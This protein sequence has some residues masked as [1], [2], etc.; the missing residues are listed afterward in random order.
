MD[1]RVMQFRVGVMVLR[2]AAH[3]RHP[4]GDVRQAAELVPR[5]VHGAR[6]LRRRP[7]RDQR[8]A[9]AQERHPHRPG[10]RRRVLEA[11]RRP[12]DQPPACLSSRPTNASFATTK[13]RV[14]TSSLLGDSSIQFVVDPAKISPLRCSWMAIERRRRLRRSDP[15]GRQ[16]AGPPLRWPSTP[17]PT[18]ATNSAWSSTQVG[19][20]L[21]TNKEPHQQ[22]PGKGR[23]HRR[24]GRNRHRS[25]TSTT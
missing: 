19:E 24:H 14:I 20:L 18:P 6:R 8:H 21:T 3:H 17:W 7:G 25:R 23:H 15:G 9:G 4:A 5:Q 16:T 22:H 12:G 1:E 13:R 11:R 2:H 10:D